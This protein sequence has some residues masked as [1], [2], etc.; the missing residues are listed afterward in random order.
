VLD[1]VASRQH[2]LVTTADLGRAGLTR[3]QILYSSQ[4]GRLI[5][6]R[7]GVYRVVGAPR[8]WEQA[9]F[10]AVLAG[11]E[12]SVASHRSAA[13]V[14]GLRGLDADCLE[15]TSP[16]RSR[17]AGVLAHVVPLP[18]ADVTTRLGLPVT[19]VARTLCD[20]GGLVPSTA[21]ARA[22]D[23]ALR[24]DQLTLN[25]LGRCLSRISDRRGLTHPMIDLVAE[26]RSGAGVGD[27]ALEARIL[28][29]LHDAGLPPPATQYRI[30]V[31]SNRRYRFDLA[32]PDLRI[33]IEA[34]GWYEHGKR[35]AFEPDLS[36]RNR[37]GMVGWLILEFADHH[38]RAEV[39]ET[40]LAAREEQARRARRETARAP[41]R[42]MAR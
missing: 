16:R 7:R 35:S 18:S 8:T 1:Q 32:Y 2:G 11:P 37:M 20:L 15:I 40:V 42:A 25:A 26:R 13:R 5:P 10:A 4:T 24:S 3:S 19:T 38:S 22:L 28:G 21:L 9:L 14:W 23:E 34:H 6:V 31:G 29:W 30:R 41:A 36:R 33:G 17:L 27:S 12:G 39:V